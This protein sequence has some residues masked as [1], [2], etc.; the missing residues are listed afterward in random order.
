MGADLKE[1]PP[2][3]ERLVDPAAEFQVLATGFGFIEGPLWHSDGY[4][5]FTDIPGDT[6]HRWDSATG[7][8]VFRSPSGKANG[9]AWDSDGRLLACEHVRSV[10]TLTEPAGSTAVLVSHW[11]GKELNSP[12]DLVVAADGAIW[13]TDPH[14]AG[15]TA[16]WGSER[17]AELDFCGVYR[18]DPAAGS[19]QLVSDSFRFPNGL[20]FSP[21]GSTLY[22]ND[23]LEMTITAFELSGAG[24]LVGE[25]LLIRQG[26]A[27]QLID[28]RMVP[29][30]PDATGFEL[31]FPDGM[32]CD[33]L[34]NVWCTGPGGVWVISPDGERIGVIETP[35]LAANLA[36]GGEQGT[37]LFITATSQL[38]ALETRVRGAS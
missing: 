4:L 33:E 3:L 6:I 27:I 20:C 37:T 25:R 11:E 18:A 21:D 22:V 32:K 29:A 28:G 23:T 8:S 2:M 36:W 7:V 34:G 26:G 16:A 5:L 38:L 15:R 31:G 13:F 12:N 17:E 10:I 9:L 14:P 24:A 1:L 19:L 35:E 30:D